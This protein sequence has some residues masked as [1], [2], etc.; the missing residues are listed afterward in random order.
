MSHRMGDHDGWGSGGWGESTWQDPVTQPAYPAGP[1]SPSPPPGAHRGSSGGRKAGLIVAGVAAAVVIIGLVAVVAFLL[2]DRDRGTE[3]TAGGWTSPAEVGEG[4]DQGDGADP[5][6]T[7]GSDEGAA[8][9]DAGS[10]AERSGVASTPPPAASPSSAAPSGTE[11][12]PTAGTYSGTLSQRG[13]RRT[14]R[15]YL[16][17]MT[18]SSQ[19]ST[20]EYPTLGC[21]GTLTPTGNSDGSRVYR[22]T[23]TSGRCDATGTWRVTKGSDTAISAE[24]QPTGADYVV[25]GQLTR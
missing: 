22:E 6:G 23:I 12:A 1:P 17:E 16:V 11:L 21:R 13:T 18:F 25:V 5:Q 15:D 4:S 20:V 8:S 7:T 2:V 14:D 3:T 24:Y 10:A 19:G 9:A